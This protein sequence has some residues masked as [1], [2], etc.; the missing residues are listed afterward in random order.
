MLRLFFL[1]F[2]SSLLLIGDVDVKESQTTTNDG[3]TLRCGTCPLP[4]C[5]PACPGEGG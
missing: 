1:F 3:V 2:V 4:E 5:P